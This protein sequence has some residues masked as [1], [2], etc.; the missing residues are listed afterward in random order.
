VADPLS[1][2]A[3]AVAVD[4]ALRAGGRWLVDTSMSGVAAWVAA[5]SRIGSSPWKGPT[6]SSRSS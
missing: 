3:S 2:I 1:G 4:A 5:G 6:T